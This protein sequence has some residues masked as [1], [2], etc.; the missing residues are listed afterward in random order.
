MTEPGA[1]LAAVLRCLLHRDTFETLVSPALADL[2]AEA[3]LGILQRRRHYAGL[4]F[5]FAWALMSDF[6]ADVGRAFG[7]DSAQRVWRRAAIWYLAIVSLMTLTALRSQAHWSFGFGTF[8]T[9]F[10][11]DGAMPWHLLSA[12]QTT[13]AVMT[14]LLQGLVSALPFAMAAAAFY[15]Y[16]Q[17]KHRTIV[18]AAIVVLAITAAAGL[19]ARPLRAGADRALYETVAPQVADPQKAVGDTQHWKDWLQSRQR[20]FDSRIAFWMDLQNAVMVIPYALF[21]VVLARR[22]G[23]NVATGALQIAV[24]MLFVM[25]LASIFLGPP[26]FP[27]GQWIGIALL[28]VTGLLRLWLDGRRETWEA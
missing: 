15:L 11:M 24:T 17:N 13:A 3:H 4:A 28:V 22:R 12:E 25:A 8:L 2:Q 10:D 26:P 20:E 23:W 18:A 27:Q 21:G 16:R 7:H 9:T 6:R 1:R 19:S 14:S 5:V